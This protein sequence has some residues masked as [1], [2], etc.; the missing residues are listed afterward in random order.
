MMKND[1]MAALFGVVVAAAILTGCGEGD[2][3]SRRQQALKLRKRLG[4]DPDF[5]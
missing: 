5:Q 3:Q 1:R 2:A 4:P